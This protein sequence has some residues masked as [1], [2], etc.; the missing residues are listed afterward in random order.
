MWSGGWL[1]RRICPPGKGVTQS[2]TQGATLDLM[3]EEFTRYHVLGDFRSEL[4]RVD[5]FMDPE[6]DP[7]EISDS[8]WSELSRL[9]KEEDVIVGHLQEAIQDKLVRGLDNKGY[10]HSIYFEHDIDPYVH[11]LWET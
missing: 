1:C 3:K 9:D 8:Q 6:G 7:K 4:D 5:P 2:R 11:I 10:E